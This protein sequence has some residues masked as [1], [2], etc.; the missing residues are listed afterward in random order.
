M[1]KAQVSVATVVRVVVAATIAFAALYLIYLVRS[2]VGLFVVALFLAIAIAP[3]VNWL[4]NRSVPRWLAVLLI[5]LT[6]L[7]AIVGVGLLIVP[8]LVTGVT[9]LSDN[10]PG[11]VD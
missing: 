2:V 8:P 4:H 11:Y 5:Y 10:I 9:D 3:A 7:S 6:G 1:G